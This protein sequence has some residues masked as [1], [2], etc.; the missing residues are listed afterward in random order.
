M[1]ERREGG[2]EAAVFS[3]AKMVRA[4]ACGGELSVDLGRRDSSSHCCVEPRNFWGH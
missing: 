1:K 3:E 4:S 2:R